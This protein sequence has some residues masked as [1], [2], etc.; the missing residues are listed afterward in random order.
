MQKEQVSFCI[1]IGTTSLKAALISECGFVFKSTVVRFS[2][3]MIQ[4]PFEIANCWKNAFFEAGKDLEISN[5][6]IIAICISGNGP[7][8]T[9]VCDN[10]T[11]TLLWNNHSFSIK[12]PIQTKSIF[13]P[14]L[15]LLK[16]NFSEIWQ[17]SEFILSGPEFLIYELTNSKVT[18]LP[19]NR[20][21]QAYWQKEELL[22][23]KISDKLLPDYVPLGYKAGFVKSENLEK[24]NISGSKKIPVFCG[25]PDFITALIGTNTLSVGKICDR[26]GSSEGI[27]LCTNKPIQMEGFR[28]LPSVIP[29]LFNT[30]Y[31]LPDTGT[32]FTEWKNSS[33]WKNKPYE[34]CIKFLLKNKNDKGYKIIFEIA[35]DVK[36]AFEKIIQQKQPFQN[37][38][39]IQIIC[40][41]GQAKNPLWMQFK[42][43]ITKLQL[44]VTNCPD[45][46][47]MG[48]AI[49]A[50]TQLKNYSSLKEAADT[51]VICDK[52]Y[53]PQ[54]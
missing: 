12:N 34:E 21:I 24:L 45:A 16:E 38:K 47:L 25:G 23:Y 37:Q 41:G 50:N 8:L 48:N 30:S 11:F 4:N 7:T 2:S 9:S 40:T 29:E 31:L 28:N 5:F 10:Q 1:D 33:E 26:S 19:E 36:Y 18:I 49:I 53:L 27:N 15:L 35:N 42:S 6:D 22:E 20:F 3:Q 44:C 52:K 43:D 54:N 14:R 39:D 17:N 32:R 13:I 51:M 46:E